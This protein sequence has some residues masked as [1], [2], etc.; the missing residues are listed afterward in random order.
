[1]ARPSNEGPPIRPS[2]EGFLATPAAAAKPALLVPLWSSLLASTSVLAKSLA[3]AWPASPPLASSSCCWSSR[4]SPIETAR[5]AFSSS[6][7]AW[8]SL[9][10]ASC[11]EEKPSVELVTLL[12]TLLLM[13]VEVV[14]PSVEQTELVELSV[15]RLDTVLNPTTMESA[16]SK[17]RREFRISASSLAL[18]PFLLVFLAA[19]VEALTAF[20]ASLLFGTWLA[21]GGLA[22]I[23]GLTGCAITGLVVVGWPMLGP[24]NNE[25]PG[26]HPGVCSVRS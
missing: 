1:M 3:S 20:D 9:E 25:L 15:D 7:P 12:F 21:L 8:L 18:Y 13:E 24:G 17:G 14:K 23:A 26:I 4:P 10:R 22:G 16:C 19:A 11:T 2:N 5:T 6:K